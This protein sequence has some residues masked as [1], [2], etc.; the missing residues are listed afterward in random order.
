MSQES[1]R[2]LDLLAQSKIT[3]EE[4]DQLLAAI[5]GAAPGGGAAAAGGAGTP[6]SPSPKYLRIAV[7]K[8]R[9]ESG[10]EDWGARS[11][12]G[13]RGFGERAREVTIRVPVSLVKNG[14]RL[15]GII[16][17]IV[18]SRLRARLR[19]RGVDVD[20]SKLDPAMIDE[21]MRE[22]G[23]INIDIDGGHARRAQVRITCE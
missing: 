7:T 1:R 11:W 6:D 4:A 9:G 3:V 13:R 2:V 19:E 20:L 12:M 18:G 15:G 23:E 8:I 17:G 5:G 21:L 16:P 10:D 14:L 22:F